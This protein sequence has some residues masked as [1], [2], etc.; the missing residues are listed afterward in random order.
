MN[1][2]E[3]GEVIPNGQEKWKLSNNKLIIHHLAVDRKAAFVSL[4]V[5]NH[6]DTRYC[7]RV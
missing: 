1:Y 7:T 4:P 6:K 5:K 3:E 2:H